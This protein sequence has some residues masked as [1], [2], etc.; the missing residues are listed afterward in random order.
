[1]AKAEN[2]R[3]SAM[4]P[5]ETELAMLV[6]GLEAVQRRRAYPLERAHYLL[7]RLIGEEGPQPVGEIARRLL[8][9]D[10]TVTRQVAAM[11]AAGL[12]RKKANPADA[13]SAL[14][15][16]TDAGLAKADAMRRQRFERMEHLFHDWT[17]EDRAE[18][19]RVI[20]R[21]NVSLRE[22]LSEGALA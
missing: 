4:E 15:H 12:V 5:L 9:D 3:S 7:V 17:E 14:V 18:C 1:M 13:R 20:G 11:T 22:V 6:R 10:S 8:L 21:L 2:A 16:V 19:A